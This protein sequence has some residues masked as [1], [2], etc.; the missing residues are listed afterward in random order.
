M[1]LE[2]GIPAP[3]ISLTD[4]E[5]KPVSLD[6][7]RGKRLWL[8]LARFV[9]CPFCSLRLH[10]IAERFDSIQR[11]HVE[12]LVVFPSAEARVRRY[13]QKYQPPFRVVADPE[14]KTFEAFGTETSWKGELRTAVNIPKV[15]R[16]L[17]NARQS[18]LSIDAAPHQMPS[19]YLID[20]EGRIARVCYGEELDDGFT[21][22]DV[23]TWSLTAA[24]RD[25]PQG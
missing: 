10:G 5:G 11:A 3:E 7:Y 18:P 25:T 4:I 8:I 14:Q 19:E 1:R 23:V 12:V 21:I 17:A 16:A 24:D 20:Q 13:V 15:L 22:K 2:A 6:D 9:A